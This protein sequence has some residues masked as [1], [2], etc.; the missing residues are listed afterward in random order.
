M[1][2]TIEKPASI[3]LEDHLEWAGGVARAYAFD[4]T[5]QEEH[6]LKSA[7][8]LAM[9]RCSRSF[10]LDRVPVGG[11]VGGAFRGFAHR[12]LQS[13]CRREARRLRNG[14]TYNTRREH[15][16]PIIVA[17]PFSDLPHHDDGSDCFD[18]IDHRTE[19]EEEEAQCP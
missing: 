5:S 19:R 1:T 17:G 11:D 3:R 13:E 18:V 14:G 7:A 2:D 4:R 16:Q 8:Y 10:N 6:D 12:Y 15:G 9:V